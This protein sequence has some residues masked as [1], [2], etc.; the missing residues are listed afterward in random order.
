MEWETK[1]ET[2][3]CPSFVYGSDLDLRL[4]RSTLW[5]N[6]SLASGREKTRKASLIWGM[7]G[8]GRTP[9]IPGWPVSRREGRK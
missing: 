2:V 8:L 5:R 9:R 1:E 7:G 4:S 6:K 3:V